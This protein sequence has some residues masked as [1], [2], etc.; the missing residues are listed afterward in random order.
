MAFGTDTTSHGVA[1]TAVTSKTWAH[2]CGAS[3]NKLVVT[4]GAGS[5]AL[6][7]RTVST[8]TYNGVALTPI[9]FSDSGSFERSEIWRLNNPPTGSA[10]NIVVTMTG[11]GANQLAAG[12]KSYIDAAAA[13]G[14]PSSNNGTTANPAVTV[15]DSASGDDVISMLST[16]NESATTTEAGTSVWKDENVGADSDFNCQ[17]QTATGANTLCAWTNSASGTS[18]AAV[19]VAIKPLAA[20]PPGLP[21]LQEPGWYPTEPQTNPLVVSSW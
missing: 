20:A 3:A 12:A 5:S 7:D 14:A 11:V 15:V 8:V 10:F 9:G 17:S 21:D 6:A 19:G 1:A 2:T 16:D 18:W 4:V 13:E